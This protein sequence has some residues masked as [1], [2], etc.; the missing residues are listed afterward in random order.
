MNSTLTSPK[1]IKTEKIKEIFSPEEVKLILGSDFQE[2]KTLC[3]KVN[4]TPKKDS[5]T[6]K[7]FFFK[8]DIE[9]LKK[10]KD[11]HERTEEIARQQKSKQLS[12]QNKITKVDSAESVEVQKLISAV[13][14]TR[15]NVVDRITKVLEDKLDGLDDIIVELV[16]SKTEIEKLR[17]K[18]EEATKE[19]YR[20]KKENDTFKPAGFGLFVKRKPHNNLK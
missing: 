8:N 15:E 5:R 7:T 16:K 19:N 3:Q 1:G 4:V 14:D 6:G 20:L 10:I 2:I 12:V 11:L 9:L 18:L 13:I 17:Q